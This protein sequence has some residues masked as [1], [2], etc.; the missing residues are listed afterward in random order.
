MNRPRTTSDDQRNQMQSCIHSTCETAKDLTPIYLC[1]KSCDESRRRR[2]VCEF[3]N[4]SDPSNEI[5]VC[6]KRYE[7]FPE[8]FDT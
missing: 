5:G 6:C 8:R 1:D 7:V 3:H 4:Y 2:P